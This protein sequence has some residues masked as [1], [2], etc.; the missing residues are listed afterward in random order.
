[1]GLSWPR[2]SHHA[3]RS[4]L[5]TLAAFGLGGGQSMMQLDTDRAGFRLSSPMV[6]TASAEREGRIIRQLQPLNRDT[7]AQPPFP[8]EFSSLLRRQ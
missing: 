5:A 7:A 6:N 1:M 4:D 2:L 8:S 3:L